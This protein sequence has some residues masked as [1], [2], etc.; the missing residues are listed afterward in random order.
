MR[1]PT[2]PAAPTIR[3]HR[4]TPFGLTLSETVYVGIAAAFSVVLVLTNIVGTKL[5]EVFGDGRPDWMPG[6]GPLVLTS[7]IITYP[8]TFLFTDL[9]AE[10]WGRRR[11][12][13]MVVLGFGM[14]VMMLAIV[15]VAIPLPPGAFWS[16]EELGWGPVE[17]QEAFRATFA[18][19]GILLGS[20][21]LAYL[22]AQLFDVR[23]YH[24]W[25]RV[26]KG[27]HMWIRNNGSTAISQLVDTII[28][29]GIFLTFAFDM[30]WSDVWSVIVAVYL[31][32]L[33]LAALDT[34][35]IYA[36][37][38]LLRRLFE[39]PNDAAPGRAPLGD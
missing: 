33:L 38:A 5:F 34:P 27:R 8:L 22:V 25:W 19:P 11:A 30:A 20:S 2:T 31:C 26:T 39:L 37:R 32:K 23:L 29:N 1:E 24:F 4:P 17:M 3:A 9:V 14:S 13:L 6:D 15:H 16:N 36:G 28:V 10:I 7:G 12:D 21:M 35:L 18:Y